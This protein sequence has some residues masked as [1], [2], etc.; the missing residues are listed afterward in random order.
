MELEQEATSERILFIDLLKENLEEE[1]PDYRLLEMLCDGLSIS[2]KFLREIN[3]IVNNNP[4]VIPDETK[5]EQ[6]ILFPEDR[7]IL[8]MIVTSRAY[9]K[10]DI[11]RI[12]NVSS[13]FH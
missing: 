5:V 2:N 4:I 10:D 7:S 12:K 6:V 11:S 3:T 13:Y 1:N 8:E 9:L